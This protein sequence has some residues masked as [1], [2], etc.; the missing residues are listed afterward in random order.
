MDER[1]P[2]HGIHYIPKN[3]LITGGAG[4]IAS[5]MVLY[6]LEKYPDY[7]IVNFDVLG[8]SSSLEYLKKAESYPNYE[9]I[10]GDIA[11]ADLVSLVLRKYNIDTVLHFAAQTHVDNSFQNSLSFTHNN[12]YGTHVLIEVCREYGKITRFIHVSTDEVY[13]ESAYNQVHATEHLSVLL[14][15]N[16][17]S[18]T[19]AAAEHIVLSYL[20]S[21]KL[22]VVITRSNNV[23][24]PHQFPEKVIPKWIC[25]LQKG[26]KLPVHGN[27]SNVRAFLYVTDAVRAFDAILHKGNVG[28]IYNISSTDEMTNLALSE[29]LI[30]QFGIYDPSL[31]IEYTED[32]K[33]NDL[34]YF[35]DDQKVRK[36]GWTQK[37]VFEEG[38][39][40]TIDW[41]RNCDLQKTWGENVSNVLQA[42]PKMPSKL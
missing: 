27:G 8:Y 37:V 21:Y 39:K 18:A 24:G 28:E 35:I 14:P 33:I 40:K 41:Y 3:I 15:T 17:Y 12:V 7:F 23:Y 31:Y 22:P 19:K 1:D 32:R 4:F 30:K 11:S 26:R 16:P 34:R 42:H 6:L 36:L 29:F 13:G 20:K 2:L 10:K 5:H 25:L 38:I 9:F